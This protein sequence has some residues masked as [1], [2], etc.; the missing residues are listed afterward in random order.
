MGLW[1][2]RS[3]G[4]ARTPSRALTQPNNTQS[5]EQERRVRRIP[6][7]VVSPLISEPDSIDEQDNVGIIVF[8]MG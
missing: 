3:A 8:T 2:E 7:K 5:G 1:R 4:T 6:S